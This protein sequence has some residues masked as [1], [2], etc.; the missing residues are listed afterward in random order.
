[1]NKIFILFIIL[2]AFGSIESEAL[3]V[4]VSPG[5][6][7]LGNIRLNIDY[8]KELIIINPNDFDIEFFIESPE[9]VQTSPEKGYIAKGKTKKIDLTIS[10]T[11]IRNQ[12]EIL[13]LNI[14]RKDAPN[15]ALAMLPG[16]A[17]ALEYDYSAA[18]PKVQKVQDEQI[19]DHKEYAFESP[20][21]ETQ[22]TLQKDEIIQIQK[23]ADPQKLNLP[24]KQKYDDEMYKVPLLDKMLIF[25]IGS[26]LLIAVLL[27]IMFA[28]YVHKLYKYS[29]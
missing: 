17:V 22:E 29:N 21:I 27:I 4:G 8:E 12:G 18:N 9:N 20:K 14:I 16:I 3:G 28:F 24:H 5:K 7:S 19:I 1:M 15:Q 6:L 25:K 11:E 13:L 10:F 26:F 2:I 23:Q